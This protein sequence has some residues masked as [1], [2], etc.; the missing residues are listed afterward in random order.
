MRTH[1]VLFYLFLLVIGC[2]GNAVLNE[3]LA[4][5]DIQGNWAISSVP[6]S[7]GLNLG[8][9]HALHLNREGLASFSELPI[10]TSARFAKIHWQTTSGN[11][12]WSLDDWGISPNH[13]WRI[14]L[15]TEKAVIELH[16][17]KEA[18]GNLELIYIPD[19]NRPEEGIHFRRR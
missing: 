8:S 15:S 10:A 5:N 7:S 3:P 17:R 6:K 9:Q 12:K 1:T 14:Q 19:A 2:S 18:S 11:G 13:A 4:P 16:V